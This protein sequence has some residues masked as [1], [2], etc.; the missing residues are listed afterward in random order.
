M[1]LLWPR[2]ARVHR[3]G[4]ATT[5]SFPLPPATTEP[6]EQKMRVS[7]SYVNECCQFESVS[8]GFKAKRIRISGAIKVIN[9]EENE[10]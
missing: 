1:G 3:H 5:E 7:L 4:T 8:G 10:L 9:R 6:P 2:L